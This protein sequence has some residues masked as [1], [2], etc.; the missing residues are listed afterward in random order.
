MGAIV[1]CI[2]RRGKSFLAA[3]LQGGGLTGVFLSVDEVYPSAPTP[4][5][6]R[7]DR[8]PDWKRSKYF[9]NRRPKR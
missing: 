6:H 3:Q 9:G 5:L 8:T 4:E 7:E 2:N 1:V